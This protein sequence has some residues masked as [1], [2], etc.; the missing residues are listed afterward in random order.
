MRNGF[1]FGFTKPSRCVSDLPGRSVVTG[2]T[3]NGAAQMDNFNYQSLTGVDIDALRNRAA[4]VRSLIS[5][6]TPQAIQIGD[7]I[8]QSKEELPHG[9]FGSWCAEAL[10][11]D[12]RLAQAYM[13]LA[14]VARK[15]G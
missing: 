8:R 9:R 1:A 3:V 14:E 12:R 13:R 11:I 5:T 4:R 10:L 6:L 7:L 15:Y 2:Q